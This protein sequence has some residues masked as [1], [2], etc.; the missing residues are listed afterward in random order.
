MGCFV[1]G[2][3]HAIILLKRSLKPHPI[4]YIYS[5]TQKH[6]T[7][8]KS[9]YLFILLFAILF[10]CG[11]KSVPKPN[12]SIPDFNK[13]YEGFIDSKYEIIMTLEKKS[14][15]LN[16]TYTYKTHGIPMKISGTMEEDGSFILEE[17]N[18]KGKLTGM[19]KGKLEDKNFSGTWS[20]TDGNL[21]MPFALIET[22]NLESTYYKEDHTETEEWMDDWTG[23]YE[24]KKGN[25]IN[26]NGPSTDGMVLFEINHEKD[27]INN[28]MKDTAYLT[29]S[30]LANF[31]ESNGNCGISFTYNSD[32]IEVME[33]EC[34][35]KHGANC[36][37]FDGVYKRKK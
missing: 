34:A 8:Q 24:D 7:M 32:Q 13:T 31:S 18:G 15:D 1:G 30:W 6:T 25:R 19:F 2:V 5:T 9:T 11:N 29:K 36:G 17:F 21:S 23:V 26:I 35:N 33:F 37:S 12:N 28:V 3:Y 20:R 22:D 16:G 4:P 27:C 10:S 14:K